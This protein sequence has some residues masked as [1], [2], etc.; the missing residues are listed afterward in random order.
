MRD[1]VKKKKEP[2][3]RTRKLEDIFF[4][5]QSGEGI[6]KYYTKPQNYKTK[7]FNWLYNFFSYFFACKLKRQMQNG[8]VL[9]LL[10]RTKGQLFPCKK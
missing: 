6:S 3:E 2:N 1:R 8:E 10:S 9:Q 5:N 7:R 4:N